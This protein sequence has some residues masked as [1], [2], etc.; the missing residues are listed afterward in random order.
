[1]VKCLDLVGVFM[2]FFVKTSLKDKIKNFD[3]QI[4]KTGLMGAMG[5]KGS[6]LIRFT[7]LETS[8]AFS[9]GHFAAGS[10]ANASRI[11]ELTDIL[12][13]NFPI[14]KE[15]RFK[16]HTLM[17]VFGDLNFRCDIDYNAC[18]NLIRARNLQQLMQYDQFLKSKEVNFNLI[19]IEEGVITFNPT[20]KY[21]LNSQDYDAKKKRVPSWCDRILYKKSKFINQIAYD[22]AEYTFSDHRPV[23]S[24]FSCHA[25]QEIKHKK[26]LLTKHIKQSVLLGL[27]SEGNSSPH[28]YLQKSFNYKENEEK[29]QSVQTGKSNLVDKESESREHINT[30]GTENEIINF[31]K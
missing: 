19:D 20:Y 7:Y 27:E 24:I 23:Y 6:C 29:K 28:K 12:N 26:S 10:S 1:M 8:F 5:N 18:L 31:F 30:Y 4:I 2:V 15:P 22:R 14:Y 21:L 25:V 11:N 16:D 9:T 13:R 17:F 3:S